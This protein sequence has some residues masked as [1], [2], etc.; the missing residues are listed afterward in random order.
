MNNAKG[1]GKRIYRGL[2]KKE[3]LKE[4]K[5]T[6]VMVRTA[7]ESLTFW[8]RRKEMMIR[9]EVIINSRTAIQ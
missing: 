6:I 5:R 3:P 2:P 4:L 7:Y 8:A 1:K 9:E